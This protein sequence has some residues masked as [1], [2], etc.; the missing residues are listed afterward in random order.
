M[1]AVL[2]PP[3]V[4][5]EVETVFHLPM[6]AHQLQELDRGDPLWIEAGNEVPHV[7]RQ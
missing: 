3:A 4:F 1:M 5:D 2:A 7:V 6:I